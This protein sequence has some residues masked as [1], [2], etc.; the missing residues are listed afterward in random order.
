[1][2]I[3][4]GLANDVHRVISRQEFCRSYLT[5]TYSRPFQ[6][7]AIGI[8]LTG[9][10]DPRVLEQTTLELLVKTQYVLVTWLTQATSH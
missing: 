5:V 1:M 9:N 7:I 3:A 4:A 8:S 2:Q 6:A 10:S